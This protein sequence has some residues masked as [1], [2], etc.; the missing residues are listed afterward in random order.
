[1]KRFPA[2]PRARGE[3]F[4]FEWKGKP[5]LMVTRL[6][7]EAGDRAGWRIRGGL[8]LEIVGLSSNIWQ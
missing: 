2:I 5:R 6:L 1:M 7:G 4:S 3:L 8:W